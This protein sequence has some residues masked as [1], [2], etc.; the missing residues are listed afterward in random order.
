MKRV[1]RAFAAID[2]NDCEN[3][4]MIALRAA[5]ELSSRGISVLVLESTL[6]LPALKGGVCSGLILSGASTRP[7]RGGFGAVEV[8]I[9]T[10]EANSRPRRMADVRSHIHSMDADMLRGYLASGSAR[11]G[12]MALD[13]CAL[14][15]SDVSS[16]SS[17]YDIIVA[18]DRCTGSYDPAN[19]AA[20]RLKKYGPD[21]PALIVVRAS[22]E[23]DIA[24]AGKRL[25]EIV[26]H[27]NA[28][29]P[30]A[31]T[32]SPHDI[33]VA[34]RLSHRWKLP[35]WSDTGDAKRLAE[36]LLMR[37]VPL[38][39]TVDQAHIAHERCEEEGSCLR[40][41]VREAL[42]ILRE[43]SDFKTIDKLQPPNFK[44]SNEEHRNR[45]AR[46]V[47]RIVGALPDVQASGIE[48]EEIVLKVVDEACGFGPI[49]RLLIDPDI[50]EI[51][52]CGPE[53]IY[54][55]RKGTI[56]RAP[57]SFYDDEHLL[58]VMERMLL[59]C[60]R[61]IDEATPFADARLPD[62]SRVHAI[63][64]PLA[65][66]GPHLTVRRFSRAISKIDDAVTNKT[67]PVEIARFLVSCVRGKISIVVSG[68]TGAG[69]TTLLNVLASQ[70]DN[71]ERIITIEDAAELKIALPHVVRL[72]ARPPNVEGAG[73]VT[74]RDLVRN[75]L[76][77]RPDRIV[78]GEC[79]GAEAL[80]MLQAMNTGHEGS[81]TTVH[82][83]SPR[84]ALARLETMVLMADLNL[85]LR[86]IREQIA[87]AV[88]LI[89]QVSRMADGSRRIVEISEVTGMEGDVISM[90]TIA[91]TGDDCELK[92]TGLTPRFN[93]R[94]I[95]RGR[96]RALA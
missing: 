47:R 14:E 55:E 41:I 73:Q 43:D 22:Q 71:S 58:G 51:M 21:I 19:S 36:R 10:L 48:A 80:D 13:G 49:E 33:A 81:L 67:M 52:V 17:A 27:E 16:L 78:V 37:S 29:R 77:M 86:A 39:L 9:N 23:G 3:A 12:R 42:S 69:K 65:V 46:C 62:G 53:R 70:I 45:V 30:I 1:C 34:S 94:L 92:M 95:S 91:E 75:A 40:R 31:F 87:R 24:F 84:D 72:E 56:E 38:T 50:T 5:S 82:A 76:R 8:S 7:S 35:L 96:D 66:D 4:L 64:P 11:I 6:R 2:A 18:V 25:K 63:I 54:V 68:G 79:R 89:I 83:N 20:A 90:Q 15:I 61:R 32:I 85:P 88:H 74:I 60:C 26:E 59:P 57:G 44:A 28:P 93:D